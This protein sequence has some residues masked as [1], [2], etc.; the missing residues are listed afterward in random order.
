[1]GEPRRA[2]P[3]LGAAAHRPDGSGHNLTPAPRSSASLFCPA[4]VTGHGD[5]CF[6]AHSSVGRRA[7]PRSM[8]S[9]GHATTGE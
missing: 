3:A 5:S 7:H 1:M 4:R 9:V 6:S 2:A 8:T